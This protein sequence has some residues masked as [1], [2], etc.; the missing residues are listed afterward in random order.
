MKKAS[1]LFLL[2]FV[3]LLAMSSFQFFM[4]ENSDL[5]DI[6]LVEEEQETISFSD[7]IQALNFYSPSF[8]I[9]T[10]GSLDSFKGKN[11]II[12]IHK[13][14]PQIFIAVAYSPPELI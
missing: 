10:E 8:Q 12:H 2:L 5:D 11:T 7:E 14:Y 1:H 6:S 3:G 13:D 4:L 9:F